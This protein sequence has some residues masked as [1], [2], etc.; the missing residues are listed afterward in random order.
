MAKRGADK[1]LT[2]Q[3]WEEEDE[4]EEAGQF[5]T[6]NANIL[7][8]RQIKVAKRRVV[9]GE[10][11]DG[12]G[13]KAAF[14]GF[15]GFGVKPAGG[16]EAP[17]FSFGASAN[18]P[19]GGISAGFSDKPLG[20]SLST[21]KPLGGSMFSNSPLKPFGNAGSLGSSSASGFSFGSNGSS[22]KEAEKDVADKTTESKLT[23]GGV[24]DQSK[25]KYLSQLKSL[26]DSVSKWIREHVEKNAYCI[27]S[28]VFK[29]YEKH[30]AIIEK[31]NPDKNG[32]STK[33]AQ[34]DLPKDENKEPAKSEAVSST[35][36]FAAAPASQPATSTASPAKFSF[37]GSSSGAGGSVFGGSG[38]F[39]GFGQTGDKPMAPMA[40]S[41]FSFGAPPKPAEGGSSATAE[42]AEY[43]PPKADVSEVKE[44]DALYTKRC[45]LF[46][47]KDGA[48]IERGVGN[49]HLK[50]CNGKTQLVMR[51]DTSLG[52]IILNI[53]LHASIPFKRQGK[54][55]VSFMCIP[56]P[57]IDP[58]ND[59][60]KPVSMLMR[61][62]TGE[63]ADE[64]LEQ[65]DKHKG[66]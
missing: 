47:Q 9:A 20:G 26:N 30:L 65:L 33:G 51:A 7:K 63:D 29:D 13:G 38:G 27:L 52:Q 59:D 18:K 8:T 41:G 36:S 1:Q 53:M 12:E 49:I 16:L 62:K 31:L 4:A 19:L 25:T 45:K 5:K 43:V 2:D 34:S 50:P 28:P 15:A 40:T 46:Y 39:S 14:K 37:G 17:K 32:D 42:D 61:V 6:A 66:E 60:K 3:N 10:D 58:K 64:L 35:F 48:W 11:G 23:R 54:N 56:N 57:P 24:A 55:N 22:I 21:E 44:D